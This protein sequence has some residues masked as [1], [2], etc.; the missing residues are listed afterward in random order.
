MP[1]IIVSI[2]AFL[3]VLFWDWVSANVV[4]V[5]TI[6]TSLAFCAAMWTAFEARKSAKAGF[7]AVRTAEASLAESRNNYRKE[8]F[9]Q[10]FSL[11]LEQ[12]NAY[13]GKVNEFSR[14]EPGW[15][16]YKKLFKTEMH[17]D[18]FHM[19]KGHFIYS[20]YMRVLYHLLKFIHEDFYGGEDDLAGRKKYSSLVRSLISNDVLFII[21]VNASYISE[22]GV[23]NQYKKYQYLLHRFDFFEHADF[24][25]LHHQ[26]DT[27]LVIEHT[28][29]FFLIRS[30]ISARFSRYL[31]RGKYGAFDYYEPYFPLSVIL[32]Y[33]YKS[34]DQ[35]HV[36]EW[37]DTAKYIV[38]ERFSS[39]INQQ[40]YSEI[41]NDHFSLYYLGSYIV[42]TDP[43][44]VSVD[45]IKKGKVVDR[46][47]IKCIIRRVIKGGLKCPDN[48]IC[49]FV[50]VNEG[51]NTI[52]PYLTL[53]ILMDDISSYLI[54]INKK[55]HFVL[56]KAYSPIRTVI[57]EIWKAE[58]LIRAQ[59]LKFP[60]S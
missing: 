25:T 46:S 57:R 16:F 4:I 3:F 19:L 45:V 28:D 27:E 5:G 50:K 18:A 38:F 10:R 21:A 6:A 60:Q 26:I 17:F 42:M 44:S 2:A 11:L 12:H 24:F 8:A 20:P 34:P 35:K 36:E 29:P 54:D 15:L 53:E 40:S 55:N 33:I 22:R 49:R 30:D 7:L 43:H 32:S 1:I 52:K 23:F 31:L 9:N 41:F 48:P 58:R 13:L 47:F 59:R 51:T 37:F 14:S 39:Q 56:G